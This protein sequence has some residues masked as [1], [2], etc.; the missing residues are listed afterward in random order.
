MPRSHTVLPLTSYSSYGTYYFD[1]LAA[2]AASLA[3]GKVA[4]VTGFEVNAYIRGGFHLKAV[5]SVFS[6]GDDILVSHDVSVTP[7]T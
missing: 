6:F 3:G 7:R 4:V 1:H 5:H 2:D